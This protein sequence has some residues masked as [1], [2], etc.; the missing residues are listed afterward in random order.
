MS[1]GCHKA[2]LCDIPALA[3]TPALFDTSMLLMDLLWTMALVTACSHTHVTCL[4]THSCLCRHTHSL[5]MRIRTLSHTLMKTGRPMP[6]FD[7]CI[8][9]VNL[10]EPKGGETKHEGTKGRDRERPVWQDR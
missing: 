8:S 7:V 1:F 2:W 4:L 5:S 9:G 6:A 3:E 10:Q